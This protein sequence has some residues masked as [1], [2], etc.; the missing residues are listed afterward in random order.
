MS[1]TLTSTSAYKV[2]VQK[3]KGKRP[4]EK[5]MRKLEDNIKTEVVYDRKDLTQFICVTIWAKG[6]IL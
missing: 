2:L 5:S 4:L 1:R 6:G 3:P